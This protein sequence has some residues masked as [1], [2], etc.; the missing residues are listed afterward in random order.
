[1]GDGKLEIEKRVERVE[2]AV[3]A[4]VDMCGLTE[5][6]ADEIHDI[7]GGSQTVLKVEEPEEDAS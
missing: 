4:M 1:M 5:E 7:L 2:S 6:E 3:K